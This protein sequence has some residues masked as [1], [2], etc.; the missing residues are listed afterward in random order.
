MLLYQRF[1]DVYPIWEWPHLL[2]IVRRSVTRKRTFLKLT[3]K[4]VNLEIN[5]TLTINLHPQPCKSKC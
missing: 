1:T 3:L 5:L 2:K 4:I